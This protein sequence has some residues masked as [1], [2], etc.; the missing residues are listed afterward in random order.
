MRL[1]IYTA[2][3]TL[4]LVGG[5]FA[6]FAV[7]TPQID[8]GPK[9][10]LSI[11]P[12]Q[13]VL[14][15]AKT[16]EILQQQASSL[17]SSQTADPAN[18]RLLQEQ[19]VESAEAP[20]PG[21]V[22]PD[23]VLSPVSPEQG[24]VE[25]APQNSE[26]VPNNDPFPLPGVSVA[27]LEDRPAE[28]PVPNAV[29]PQNLP[30]ANAADAQE[31][32]NDSAVPVADENPQ[33]SVIAN[34]PETLP[35]QLDESDTLDETP[36]P[37][38]VATLSEPV[39]ERL[40]QENSSG[41]VD[42]PQGLATAPSSPEAPESPA[43]DAVATAPPSGENSGEAPVKEENVEE[44][45][46]TFNAFV[47]SLKEKEQ[48]QALS[49]LPPPPLPLKRPDNIPAP[50]RTASLNPDGLSAPRV[51]ILLRGLGR[52]DKNSE[53]AVN[54]LPSAISLGV[55]PYVG[56]AQQW[57]IEA[58]ERGHEIIVQVP[59][60]PANYPKTNP[61]PETLL[62]SSNTAENASKLRTVLDRFQGYSGVTNYFGGKFLQSAE[63]MR[64]IMK[65]IKSRGLMYISEPNSSQALV[66][67]LAAEIGV[68]YSGAD[69]VIDTYQTPNS[70]QKSLDELVALARRQGSA[71][72]MAY[73]SRA[74]IDQLRIWSEK[75][76][77]QGIML[78]PVGV[79]AHTPGPS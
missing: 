70:I 2:T 12:Y 24:T 32:N 23:V 10:V 61:G 57:A 53:I 79:L 65:D 28:Q 41:V 5:G 45:R 69:I 48:Q 30:P 14:A 64:P 62:T 76:S 11:E 75:V 39:P 34:A 67:K 9:V 37:Q 54:S 77:S 33:D 15:E 1:L 73:A 18:D 25:A 55:A 40:P 60:E 49:V 66:R 29:T 4:L 6:Y 20:L 47:A 50:I 22:T 59:F 74:S 19:T 42:S 36:S 44:L 17:A 46:A 38:Q 71:I 31:A 43:G 58:R 35:Q 3:I 72:G 21:T 68:L 26:P 27:G 8:T 52:N 78:V 16:R 56:S 13:A 7:Q 63:T 51:A